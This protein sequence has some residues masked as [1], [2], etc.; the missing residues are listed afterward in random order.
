MQWRKKQIEKATSLTKFNECLGLKIFALFIVLCRKFKAQNSTKE[1]RLKAYAFI[2][3]LNFKKLFEQAARKEDDVQGDVMSEAA[4]LNAYFICHNVQVPEQPR[5][6]NYFIIFSIVKLDLLFFVCV[7]F[8][9]DR[10]AS[11]PETC[12]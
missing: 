6:I 9:S 12:F 1:S 4:M 7:F 8:C 11:H 3:S 2:L 5:T 10:D